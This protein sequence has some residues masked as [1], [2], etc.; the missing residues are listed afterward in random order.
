MDT[1]YTLLFII[2]GTLIGSFNNVVIH[3]YP[4]GESI[5]KPRS[6][7][8]E[9]GHVLAWYENI[10]LFSYLFLRG[11]CSSCKE[12]IPIRYFLVEL[13][14]G[15]LFGFAFAYY[16]FSAE[17]IFALI[18]IDVGLIIIY[19]D[20]DH[21]FIPDL[22]NAILFVLASGYVVYQAVTVEGFNVGTHLFGLIIGFMLLYMIR[23]FGELAYKREALGLGDVKLLAVGGFY[24]GWPNV[25]LTIM[26][27][28]VIA[29]VIELTLIKMKKKDR[30]DEIAFGPYLMGV[31]IILMFFGN[32]L[33]SWYINLLA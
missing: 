7:C 30:R 10:P 16:G 9:C 27:A 18:F 1:I 14:T 25:L 29:S 33:I 26:L 12:P 20:L 31:M 32:D 15:L 19:I 24:L 6:R 3:R 13:L 28:S 17:L 5:V 11:R 22:F 8:P 23:I 21:H 4:R 2:L